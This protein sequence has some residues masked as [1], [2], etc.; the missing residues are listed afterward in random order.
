MNIF[1]AI[2]SYDGRIFICCSRSLTSELYVAANFGHNIKITYLPGCSLITHAR[3]MLAAQ[4]LA[5]PKADKLVFIDADVGWAPGSI[6][7]LATHN[8]PVVAGIYRYKVAEE[9][10]PMG[11]FTK[12]GETEFDDGLMTSTA[13]PMGFT[14]ISRQALLDFK[15]RT[16]ERAYKFRGEDYHAFFEAPFVP[17]DEHNPAALIGEDTSFCFEWR[18]QGGKI[19]VD[20]DLDLIHTDGLKEFAGNLGDYL[21]RNGAT[22]TAPDDKQSTAA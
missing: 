10:Y 16:P 21:R 14:A 11:F 7:K 12:K 4:F 1:V 18:K 2:P 5:D 20:P 3:N 6:V 17:A 22:Y 8:K 9:G 19:W 15:E 13:C